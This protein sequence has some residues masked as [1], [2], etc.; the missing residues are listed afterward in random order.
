MSPRKTAVLIGLTTLVLLGCATPLPP[1]VRMRAD[2]PKSCATADCDVGVYVVPDGVACKIVVDPALLIVRSKGESRIRFE[3]MT[4]GYQFAHDGIVFPD[5][6]D[7]FQC[8]HGPR[9][10]NCRNRHSKSEGYKYNV[11]VTG[12]C[13][14]PTLDPYVMN[15]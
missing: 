1:E 7:E 13:Y 6:G 9:Q 3:L 2:K 5:A 11:K 4:S 8:S 15:D 12:P 10:V 14:T